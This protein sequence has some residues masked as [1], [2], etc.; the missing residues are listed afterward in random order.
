MKKIL[1]FA[2]ILCC[3]S[4]L[5]AQQTI[6]NPA[7][8]EQSSQELIITRVGLFSDSTVIDLSVENKLAQGGW[9]CADKK[10]YI[11]TPIEHHRFNI[12]KTFSV[13]C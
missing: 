9:Y 7:V 13:F 11:E 6:V 5:N 8:A 1:L 12:I 4:Y 10:I 2:I 3:H